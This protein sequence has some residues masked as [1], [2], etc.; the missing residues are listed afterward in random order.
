MSSGTNRTTE[1][2]KTAIRGGNSSRKRG[3]GRGRTR[4]DNKKGFASVEMQ[5]TGRSLSL[6]DVKGCAEV[7]QGT[8]E[9][10][11]IQI[12]G[13]H[14]K[15]WGLLL[16]TFEER[17]EDEGEAQWTQWITLLNTTTTKNGVLPKVQERLGSITTL[18]PG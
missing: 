13:I 5:S 2:D 11:I 16:D 12:P 4:R 8:T 3:G 1:E 18:Q 7:T 14:E 15:T 9:S 6:N 10:P 17:L